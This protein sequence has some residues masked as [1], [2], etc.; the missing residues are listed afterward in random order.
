MPD[1]SSLT[2]NIERL[3]ASVAWWNGIIIVMMVAA[4]ASATGLVIVQNIAFKRADALASA[5]AELSEAKEGVANEK[6]AA[7]TQKAAEADEAAGKSNEAAGNANERAA[8]LEV[9]AAQLELDRAKLE[10]TVSFNGPRGVALTS[11]RDSIITK[12]AV[13]SGQKVFHIVCGSE[14]RGANQSEISFADNAFALIFRDAGWVVSGSRH[15]IPPNEWLLPE[16]DDTCSN[17]SGILVVYRPDAP[18][19][20]RRAADALTGEIFRV[21]GVRIE[22]GDR[23]NFAVPPDPETISLFIAAHPVSSEKTK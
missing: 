4:A 6:I 9:K 16:I 23:G 19:S 11:A 10:Q 15:T 5:T 20:T 3:T 22:A 14:F 21:L 17:G 1:I 13:F 8:A 7:A 12:L 2:A 18:E